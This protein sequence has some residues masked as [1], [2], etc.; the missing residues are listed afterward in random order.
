LPESVPCNDGQ[1]YRLKTKEC[2]P[3]KNP[4][5]G[6]AGFD[7]PSENIYTLQNCTEEELKTTIDNLPQEGGK[8]IMPECTITTKN[9]IVLPSNVIL[10]GA[11]IGK[12]ILSNTGDSAV[13][14][15]GENIIVRNFTVEGN[16]ASLNGIN[17]YRTKGNILV[18][19]IEA[20]NFKPDQGSGISFLTVNTLENS[21]VTI[22]Y[23][24]TS[25]SLHGIAVKVHTSAKML[26]YSN[27]A[28][29]NKNY[30]IDMST[31]SDIEV[32]GNYIHDNFVAGAKSPLA[33]N[34]IYHHNNINFNGKTPTKQD[35]AGLVYMGTNKNAT[36]IV[37]DNDISF[38][39]GKAFEC[40]DAEFHRL[41]LKNN[42]VTGSTDSNGYS[43]GI[44]GV[45]IVE[46]YGDHGKI[47]DE[48]NGN[49][50][51]Y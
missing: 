9:G 39:G 37:E 34:I 3:L 12:T 29:D 44:V 45:D 4:S 42:I 20:K 17:G 11:G 6:F 33:D 46:V 23:C 19:F 21:R 2:L 40:W 32:A 14:L 35:N 1:F 25:N 51:R 24:D 13:S 26:I 48:K 5:W 7:F 50:I 22:R 27:Q 8:I 18:E 16:S 47:W 30:G 43:I 36:I 28:Y 49:V 15:H 10:E 41:I 31:S 38:N